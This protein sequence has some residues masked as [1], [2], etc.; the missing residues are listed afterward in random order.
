MARAIYIPFGKTDFLLW[1]SDA[2]T[3]EKIELVHYQGAT[4]TVLATEPLDLEYMEENYSQIL[5]KASKKYDQIEREIRLEEELG[6]EAMLERE[7]EHQ[8]DMDKA[9]NF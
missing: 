3:F 6:R 9:E 7:A 8:Y 5:D 1:M 4:Q 2:D